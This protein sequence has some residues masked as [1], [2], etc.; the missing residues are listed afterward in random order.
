MSLDLWPAA[1]PVRHVR[2]ARETSRLDQL[3]R[4]YCGGLGLP[5]L[6]RFPDRGGYRGVVLGLPGAHHQLEFTQNERES[7]GWPPAP[8]NLLVLFFDD[9]GRIGQVV[10]RLADLGYPP[11]EAESSYWW[12]GNGA[13][14]VE[15]PDRWQ[16]VLVPGPLTVV[17]EST[18]VDWYV[19]DRGALR[20]LFE[21]AEDS[22]AE[23][24]SYMEAGR[25]LVAWA[26]S[27]VVGYIQLVRTGKADQAEIRSMAVLEA[28]QGHGIGG[29][30]IR[31]ALAVLA[32]EGMSTVRVAAAAA[33][34][35]NLRFYQRQGFRMRSIERDAFTTSIGYPPGHEVAGIEL[36]DRVW[37]DYSLGG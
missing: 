6:E 21:L 27:D 11:V 3:V 20:P 13:I 36:R 10:A 29:R 14:T 4:F 22:P 26:G 28:S 31:A 23:L 34:T 18:F 15:D 32:A 5:E 2:V 17:A 37:L 33:D 19:G 30:L 24:N 7:P 16:V 9:H 8:G 1:L 25:V 12:T 35:T